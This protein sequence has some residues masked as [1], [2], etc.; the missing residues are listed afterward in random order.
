MVQRGALLGGVAQRMPHAAQAYLKLAV[1]CRRTGVEPA[2]VTTVVKTARAAYQ[3]RQ[4]QQ[5]AAARLRP[6]LAHLRATAG[7]GA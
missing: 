2:L 7:H 6:I 1:A 5:D 4:R 3:A